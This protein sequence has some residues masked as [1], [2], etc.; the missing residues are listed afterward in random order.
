[1]PPARP[2]GSLTGA[3]PGDLNGNGTIIQ[4]LC[5]FFVCV[6]LISVIPPRHVLG[7]VVRRT[8]RNVAAAGPVFRI[9]E[10]RLHRGVAHIS[11]ALDACSVTVASLAEGYIYL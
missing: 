9:V 1:M 5:A 4:D 7:H 3:L 10:R 6:F 8:R 11:S 2:H